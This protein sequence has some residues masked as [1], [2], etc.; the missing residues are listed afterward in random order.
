M[1]YLIWTDYDQEP[2]WMSDDEIEE[3]ELA[4]CRKYESYESED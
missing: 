1:N 3:Y 4:E 2:L